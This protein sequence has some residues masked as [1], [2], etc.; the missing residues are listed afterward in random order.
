MTRPTLDT[1]EPWL[2]LELETQAPSVDATKLEVIAVEGASE[3]S[4]P[5]RYDVHLEWS[6][7]GYGLAPDQLE[8]LLRHACGLRAASTRESFAHGVLD[9]IVTESVDHSSHSVRYRAVLVPRLARLA[10]SV[11]SRVFQDLDV[12]AM[13]A[14]ILEEHGLHAQDDYELRLSRSYPVSEYTLQYQESD[15]A[16]L[17]RHLEHHGI[18]FHFRQDPDRERLVVS[19]ANRGF[20]DP[21][22]V[23][24]E[25]RHASGITATAAVHALERRVKVGPASVFL[26]DF[27]WR[28]PQVMLSNQAQADA[29]T[30]YA[31]HQEH[32]AHYKT[33]AEGA[34]LA[35]VRA[36]EVRCERARYTAQATAFELAAGACLELENHPLGGYPTEYLVVRSTV[37][38]VDTTDSQQVLELAELAHPYRPPR[39]A[40]RPRVVGFVHGRIDGPAHSTAAPIDEHGR[41]KV[42]LPFDVNGR[43]GGKA[44]RWIRVAQPAAGPGYGVHIPMH[45]GAEVAIGHMDGDPDRPVILGSLHNADAT[46]PVNADNATQSWIRTQAGV[47]VILDDDV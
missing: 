17:S 14:S 34:D 44:S 24:Y 43:P 41:Y 4:A 1:Q 20:A 16:F 31:M 12:G 28:T 45:I 32:G 47:R 26:T 21:V 23:P 46:N 19:D 27:N 42:L 18:H 10:Y 35:R 5:Y 11:R 8:E 3:L 6:E 29:V 38:L 33:P 39:R 37:R 22:R 9:S 7:D 36:E 15:L 25:A 30:G 40:P 2:D 13:T